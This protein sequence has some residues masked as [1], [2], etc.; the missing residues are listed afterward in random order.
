MYIE[1]KP[2]VA[3]DQK[4]DGNAEEENRGYGQSS[5]DIDSNGRPECPA[6]SPQDDLEPDL[7]IHLHAKKELKTVSAP[8]FLR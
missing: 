8:S 1:W 3:E 4:G 7:K 2:I 6:S 5:P